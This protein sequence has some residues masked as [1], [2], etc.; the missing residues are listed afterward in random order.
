MNTQTKSR[1]VNRGWLKKQIAAGNIEIKTDMILTDDYA[2]DA[3]YNCQKSEWKK[4]D[5]KDF[6]DQDFQFKS[7]RAYWNDERTEI[8]WTMLANHYYTCRLI[9]ATK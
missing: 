9:S 5:I 3:A 7:G 2:F 8:S 4:A 6:S 1:T